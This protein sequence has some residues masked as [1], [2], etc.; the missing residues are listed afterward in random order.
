MNVRT[1]RISL[2]LLAGA[3]ALGC[4]DGYEDEPELGEAEVEEEMAPVTEPEAEYAF[5]EWDADANRMLDRD[6]WTVW[7]TETPRWTA[8]D[9]DDEEGLGTE[10]FGVTTVTVWDAD[11]DD[12]VSEEEW[13]AGTDRWFGDDVDYGVWTDWDG[14][15]DSFLDANEVAEGFEVNG[16]YDVVDRDAD[17]VID[18]EELAD[19][20]FDV[21]DA[22]DDSEIDTTEWDWGEQH[23]YTG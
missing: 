5:V 21:F 8:W 6:E 10:E 16:L 1:N 3:V 14:D 23:G 15:G 4:A 2:A 13:R 20:F 19:W 18:D 12:L 7:V 9:V 11:D 17:A 22:N